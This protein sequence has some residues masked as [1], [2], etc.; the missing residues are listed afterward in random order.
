MKL[1]AITHPLFRKVAILHVEMS[2]EHVAR[3]TRQLVRY[4]K[5]GALADEA[6]EVDIASLAKLKHTP[7]ILLVTGDRVVSKP[8][9]KN[10]PAT[11]R[12][13]HNEELLWTLSTAGEDADTPTLSFL[14]K[15]PLRE[16]LE[17]IA[18][19]KLLLVD[20]WIRADL[21]ADL[22]RRMERL[23]EERF[24]STALAQS[25]ICGNRLADFAF[26]RL[27]LPVLLLLFAVLLGNFFLNTHYSQLYGEKQNVVQ[28]SQQQ[29]RKNAAETQKKS[30]LFGEYT[31]VPDLSYPLLADRIASYI[32]EGVKLTALTLFPEEKR[33]N[34]PAAKNAP[35]V[36]YHTIHLRGT[37][38][39]P[40]S[41][42]LLAQYLEADQLF[43][44]VNIVRIDRKKGV[45]LFEFELKIAL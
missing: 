42:S 31:Q 38:E 19:D 44:R 35:R 30:Q 3:A 43:G 28:R 13:V 17:A 40:G 33:A 34:A 36:D 26:A 21:P 22:P 23:R 18:R 27:F 41:V 4:A 1:P 15:E 37:A 11:E 45:G 10:D 32:P 20:T 25:P 24:A 29:D 14:R 2:G 7:V 5:G 6:G 12:V 39:V 9:A 16:W 8:Y